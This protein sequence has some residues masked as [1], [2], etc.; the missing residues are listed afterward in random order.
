MSP[1]ERSA[2]REATF[3]AVGVLALVLSVAVIGYV[4]MAGMLQ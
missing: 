2:A 3:L 1:D 4:L